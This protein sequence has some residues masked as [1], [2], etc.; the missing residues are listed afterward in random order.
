MFRDFARGRNADAD[1]AREFYDEYFAV[2]DIAAEFY[3]DTARVV[4][5]N[6]DL[7]RGEMQWKGRRV[8]PGAIRW[9][10][11]T[12]EAENDEM[13]PPGQTKAAHDLCHGIPARRKH[14][15]LQ[16]GVGHYGVFSGTRFEQ[17]IY[18]KIQR[19]IASSGRA[20]APR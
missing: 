10:L 19:F 3:L 15:H 17:E 7:A 6:H 5:M 8:D 1:R 12:I 14:H 20:P 4:F 18:P 9:S 2:I 11:L 16:P 13:C